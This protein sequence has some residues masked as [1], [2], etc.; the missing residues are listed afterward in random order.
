MCYSNM[1]RLQR[2]T[3]RPSTPARRRVLYN[4]RDSSPT[5]P[6]TALRDPTNN[7]EKTRGRNTP[8]RY[9]EE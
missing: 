1:F 8:I 4:K 2:V 5:L 6:T 9:A 7:P 3:I